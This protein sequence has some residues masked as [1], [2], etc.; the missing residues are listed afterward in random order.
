M[1]ALGE[2]VEAAAE[3]PFFLPDVNNPIVGLTGHAFTLG[4]VQI[5]L[6]GSVSWVDVALIKIV[7]VG[8]GWY[9][10]RLT[11]A[12]CVTE[13]VVK[14]RVVD[15]SVSPAFQPTRGSE[16]I[17]TL[18]GDIG[19]LSTG[20]LMFYL[21]DEN[22]PVFGNP[23]TGAFPA[24]TVELRL[25]N[26]TFTAGDSSLVVEF[27]DGLYGYPLDE[28]DT[29]TRGKAFIYASATGA[30]PFSGYS[31]I[32]GV[33]AYTP[34]IVIPTPIPVITTDEDLVVVGTYQDLIAGAVARLCEYSKSGNFVADAFT[35][36]VG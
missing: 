32:L 5:K 19:V 14:F 28:T 10:I 18:G 23:I 6:P 2:T 35:D 16:T 31:T 30:Q 7:E 25:P 36:N 3:I 9:V 12:Q 8:N 29:A 11:A 15:A 27:G 17:S 22:D 21:P 24:G 20:Y 1:I 13:G 26:G 4:E 33:G 34:E